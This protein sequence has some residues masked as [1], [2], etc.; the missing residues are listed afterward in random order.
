MNI[1]HS[2][3]VVTYNHEQ[4]IKEC[5]DSLIN[6]TELPF[7]IVISDDC[8]HDNT[9]N[10]IEDYKRKRPNLFRI[11]RNEKNLGIFENIHTIRGYAKGNVINFLA[12][13]D[14]YK[15]Q[16]IEKI[17]NAIKEEKLR[18]DEDSFI[19]ALNSIHLYHDGREWIWNNYKYRNY[20]VMRLKLRFGISFRSIGFSKKIIE[21]SPSEKEV[22][23]SYPNIG[24]GPDTIKGFEELK[25][26]ERIIYVDYPGPVYRLG[27]GITSKHYSKEKYLNDL[28]LWGIIK[29]KY[30]DCWNTK[31]LTFIK[32]KESSLKFEYK[33]S[34]L[35]FIRTMYLAIINFNNFT[36]NQPWIRSLKIFLPKKI[37]PFL[38]YYIFPILRRN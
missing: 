37:H 28:R 31:D 20:S 11:F 19:I 3:L 36:S 16:T 34:F 15:H 25:N 14:L 33:P 35:L 29:T 12:G 22:L 9:W 6:Q 13:D 4:Y 18:P 1:K 10:I 38:K 26:C 5:L 21:K 32:Y 30:K 2:V 23:E 24:L 17:S 8:S 7:E 27:V